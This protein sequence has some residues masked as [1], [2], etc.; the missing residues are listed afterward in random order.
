MTRT[1]AL[2]AL[3]ALALAAGAGCADEDGTVPA[4]TANGVEISSQEVVDELE[5]IRGND[6]FL[7]Q[8]EEQLAAQGLGVVGD[9][10]GTFDSAFVAQTLTNRILY[11]IVEAEVAER[12][13]EID[14]ACRAAAEEAAAGEV[15]G[16]ELFDAFDAGYREYLVDRLADLI[17][18]QGSL[19][20]YPCT[21]Q[22]DD[23]LLE[24]YFDEHAEEFTRRCVVLAQFADGQAAEEFRLQVEAGGDF[25]TLGAALPAESGQFSD[26]GCDSTQEILE[27]IP[28]LADLAVGEVSPVVL[29]G[30]IPVVLSVTDIQEGSFEEQRDAVVAAVGGEIDEAF[31]AWLDE[32]LRAAEVTVDPRYGT[33]NANPETGGLPTIERPVAD[34]TEPDAQLVPED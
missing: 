25:A 20:G 21:I 17:A 8:T 3:A 34:A 11:A 26:V 28:S 10:E 29:A 24:A 1:R 16:Q 22:D 33:W 5:A 27:V 23:A 2:A 19:A 4:A 14:D 7:A 31:N 13:I 6:A 9:D 15:G 32:E 12:D 18:L 30:D